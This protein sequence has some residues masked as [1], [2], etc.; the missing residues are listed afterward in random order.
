[1][2]KYFAVGGFLEI[3]KPS[4]SFGKIITTYHKVEDK[5]LDHVLARNFNH[6]LGNSFQ[7]DRIC[8]FA[9]EQEA[10]EFAKQ[11][12]KS[13]S[14][15][16]EIDRCFPYFSVQTK[17]SWN[18]SETHPSKEFCTDIV[19][20]KAHLIGYTDYQGDK[21]PQDLVEE[22]FR[23]LFDSTFC[24]VVLFSF[25]TIIVPILYTLYRQSIK[26]DALFMLENQKTDPY[27]RGRASSH[28][29]YRKEIEQL[30]ASQQIINPQTDTNHP[31]IFEASKV[32]SH[33]A[34]PN[35]PNQEN[36]LEFKF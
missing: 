17:N 4:W 20:K 9:S 6:R 18:I 11:K 10:I 16:N 2:P 27:P 14:A 1:M 19:S 5:V 8:L 36:N 31:H 26:E 15:G 25:F 33:H 34:F 21:Y 24:I 28:S 3:A 13:Q 7:N 22:A 12:E 32:M 23:P 30:N 35:N 29:H